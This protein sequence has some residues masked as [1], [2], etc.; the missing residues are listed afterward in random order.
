MNRV[1]VENLDPILLGGLNSFIGGTSIDDYYFNL[2]LGKGL[3]E[4]AI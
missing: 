4:D 1:V 2:I 3:R